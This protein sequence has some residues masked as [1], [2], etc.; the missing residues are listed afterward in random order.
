MSDYPAKNQKMAR[1]SKNRNN[2]KSISRALSTFVGDFAH[3][4]TK[5]DSPAGKKKKY[6]AAA[7]RRTNRGD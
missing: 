2:P 5:P 4:L 7:K 6:A 3:G 1:P